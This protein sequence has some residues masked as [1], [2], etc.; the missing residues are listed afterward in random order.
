ML[1]INHKT[2]ENDNMII[3]KHTIPEKIVTLLEPFD[4]GKNLDTAVRDKVL[5]REY[6]EPYLVADNTAKLISESI[7]RID[8]IDPE[9]RAPVPNDQEL[10]ASLAIDIIGEN[11]FIIP[12]KSVSGEVYETAD[13]Y[14]ISADLLD[15]FKQG[16]IDKYLNECESEEE[17]QDCKYSNV[18][19]RVC[20]DGQWKEI[21]D[22]EE[23]EK[24]LETVSN[25][26]GAE[27]VEFLKEHPFGTYG[28]YK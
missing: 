22:A 11:N 28:V 9:L 3:S 17:T 25:L 4:L 18:T 12:K 6:V 21:T 10:A 8:Y 24:F 13:Y 15:L 16:R 2:G 23:K 19:L 27:F 20:E 14:D 5:G 1:D 26:E 7:D